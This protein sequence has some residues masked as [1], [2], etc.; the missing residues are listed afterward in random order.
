M[1]TYEPYYA[2]D[3]D[4][5]E[6]K[7]LMAQGFRPA[8]E[9]DFQV[10]HQHAGVSPYPR[11]SGLLVRELDLDAYRYDGPNGPWFVVCT[12]GGMGE[13]PQWCIQRHPTAAM[14]S[15]WLSIPEGSTVDARC[16]GLIANRTW[17]THDSG[18]TLVFLTFQDADRVAK[19]LAA[20]T[21]PWADSMEP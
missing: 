14:S 12:Q 20:G 7:R 5:A 1:K 4:F 13:A 21:D 19:R 2:H 17:C 11:Y 18:V 8:L 10:H 16:H 6:L 3:I 15:E 9:R